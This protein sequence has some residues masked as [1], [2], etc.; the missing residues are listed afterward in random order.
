M[1]T[2][3]KEVR[4]EVAAI[5]GDG[6]L[7]SEVE[8]AMMGAYGFTAECIADDTFKPVRMQYIGEWSIKDYNQKK[9]LQ[10]RH[11][12]QQQLLDGGDTELPSKEP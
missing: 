6:L 3:L 8:D 2:V 7:V 5:L 10:R 11:E 4:D 12:K 9:I 1:K